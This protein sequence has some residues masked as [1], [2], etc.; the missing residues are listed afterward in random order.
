M[1]GKRLGSHA[2]A[3]CRNVFGGR[4]MSTK[5]PPGSMVFHATRRSEAAQSTA[6]RA[7]HPS[8]LVRRV[9]FQPARND[10]LGMR[11]ARETEVLASPAAHRGAVR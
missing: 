10:A 5:L 7:R 4:R 3:T 2:R 9:H 11:T 1:P 6:H 8:G